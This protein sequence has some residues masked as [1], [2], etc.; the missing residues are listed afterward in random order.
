MSQARQ[1]RGAIVYQLA[2]QARQIDRPARL[3]NEVGGRFIQAACGGDEAIETVDRAIDAVD[4]A[5]D[6]LVFRRQCPT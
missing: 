6:P 4:R 5:L 3:G 2:E 1:Q